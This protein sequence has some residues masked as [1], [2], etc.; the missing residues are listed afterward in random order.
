MKKS[1]HDLSII[2]V[3]YNTRELLRNC[4]DSIYTNTRQISFEIIVVDNSSIDG[5]P[6]MVRRDFP[7][8]K[9][10]VNQRNVGFSKAANQATE[11]SH[12]RYILFL[13]SDTL[14]LPK[15][16]E[17]LVKFMG[18]HPR[19][20]AVSP[21]VL[22]PDGSPQFSCGRS[23]PTL[24]TEFFKFAFLDRIFSKSRCFGKYLLSYWDHKSTR[25]VELLSGSCLMTRSEIVHK[26]GKMDEDFFFFGED[27]DWCF[28]IR[29]IGWN[30][31]LYPESKIIHYGGESY[32]KEKELIHF[33]YYENMS[34]FFLKHYGR[35]H[36]NLYH[37]ITSLCMLPKL[38]ILILMYILTIKSSL[39][40]R[41]KKKLK[42]NCV[43]WK[44]SLYL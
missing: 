21:L 28:R 40:K 39:K 26:G 8:V 3:S 15:S 18:S 19:T 9:L 32:R 43:I 37:H 29:E 27:I 6:E 36:A 33:H 16:L 11:E 20:G 30:I 41:I 13:N 5:S 2:I 1:K 23:F 38:V 35:S 14:I 24:S 31:Y 22:N 34:K 12:G 25:D 7:L 42:G 4:L 17:L 10:L 44:W